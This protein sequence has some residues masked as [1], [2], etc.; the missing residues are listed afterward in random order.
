MSRDHMIHKLWIDYLVWVRDY[1]H[2]L[3][4]RRNG[5]QYTEERLARLAADFADF[6]APLYGEQTARQFGD[7]LMRHFRLLS[8][9]TAIMHANE[10]P[11]P[12]REMLYANETDIAQLLTEM[13]PYWDETT[14]ETLL[15]NQAY[16][17]EALIWVLHRDGYGEAV[18]QY[19]DVYANI[20]RIVAYMIEGTTRQFE[21]APS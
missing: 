16:L 15:Q 4:L 5:L 9:Y 1:I 8:E 2:L 20:D 21:P 10:D 14:W 3:M 11:E 18:A 17:E 7:L 19:E 13:N 12:L 6:F